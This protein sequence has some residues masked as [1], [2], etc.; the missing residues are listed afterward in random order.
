M[1]NLEKQL[2][3]LEELREYR[4]E[5]DNLPATAAGAPPKGFHLNN[6]MF[7]S[8]DAELLWAMVRW[9]EPERI[10]EVGSGWTTALMSQAVQRNGVPCDIT[11]IDPTPPGAAYNRKNVT[12]F[13]RRLQ[14]VGDVFSNLTEDDFI[15]VDSSHVFSTDGEIDLVLRALPGLSGVYVMFHDIFLPEDYP[16]SWAMRGYNEQGFVQEYLEANPDV[17]VLFAANFVHKEAPEA[18]AESFKSYNPDRP[19]GPGALW[20][21]TPVKKVVETTKPA[22]KKRSTKKADPEPAEVADSESLSALL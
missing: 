7:G 5:Y 20:F 11:T 9:I 19:I 4:R 3:T 14:E 1:F 12:L 22:A 8:I 17:E 18:L 2:E 15:I 21:R 10:V 13:E 6:G 16:E